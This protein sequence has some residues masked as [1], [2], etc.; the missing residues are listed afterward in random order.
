M[1]VRMVNKFVKANSLI[2]GMKKV[3]LFVLFLTFSTALFSQIIADHTVVDKYDV[4]PQQYIDAVKKMLV[5]IAGESH[6]SGYRI[7]MNLLESINSKFQVITYDGYIP[8]YTTSSLRLGR[9]DEVGEAT[10]YTSPAAIT[11]YKSHITNQN[12]TGN[13]YS[14]MGFGWCWDMTW[15]NDPGGTLDP[16]IGR[17]HV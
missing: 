5:D 3:L 14:V 1:F 16:E 7:G 6:S 8:G 2:W 10:F 4:I 15:I 11:A 9:H 12:N 17:A 13:T